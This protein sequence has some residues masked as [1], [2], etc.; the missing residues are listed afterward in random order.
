MA[1]TD[2][3]LVPAQQWPVTCSA[4]DFARF[5][6][7]RDRG[8]QWLID[9]IGDDGTPAGA[10]RGNSWWRAPWALVVGGAPEAAARML[11]WIERTALTDD[12]DL[13]PGPFDAPMGHSPV[14]HLSPIA[15]A[16]WLTGRFDTANRIMEAMAK[17]TDERT[18]GVYDL[19]DF[20]ADP[21]QDTLKTSQLG[22]SALMT[23][24]REVA[25]GVAEWLIQN[26]AEQPELPSRYYSSR[27]HGKLITEFADQEAFSRVLDF[28]R[29]HQAYFL[30]GIAAAFLAGYHQ[31]TGDARAM[32][33]AHKYLAITTAGGDLQFDDPSTVQIC[34]FGWGAAV[35]YAATSAPELRPWVTR[36]GEWFVR[37]QESD[38]AWAPSAYATSAPGLL[39]YYWKTAEHVM[40]LSQIVLAL[41]AEGFDSPVTT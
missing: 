22:I 36:M 19:R 18:G 2:T 13:R 11:G 28:G 38:G 21:V 33:S 9:R 4:E 37:R 14:Y 26:Y 31:Q 1:T 15:I 32:A 5:V 25:D 23:G 3:E 41:A 6:A 12:G 24:H 10:D 35:T 34:K 16:A 7:A 8:V 40:E 20:A 29:R 39:D 17:F 27:R 30:P